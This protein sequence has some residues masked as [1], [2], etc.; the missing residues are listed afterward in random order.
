MSTKRHAAISGMRV[1][2]ST[3]RSDVDGDGTKNL[4]GENLVGDGTKFLVG[5][6][7]KKL[8]GDG[9][10]KLDG[11]GTKF[12]VGDGAKKLDGDGTKFLVGS[13]DGL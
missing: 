10:K 5:D 8:D 12:L 1:P 6:G 2:L 13:D 3:I 9:A 4:V 7:A 11:D